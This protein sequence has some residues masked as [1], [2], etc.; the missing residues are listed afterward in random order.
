MPSCDFC[1]VDCKDQL[2]SCVCKKASYC[3]KD[4]QVKDWKTHK[5]S[6]PPFTVRQTPGGGRGLFASRRIK[7]GRI[8]LD[9]YPLFTLSLG[10]DIGMDLLS[11]LEFRT[12]YFP[13]IDEQTKATI[14][15]LDDP[16]DIFKTLD[17]ETV[18]EIIR[19]IPFV[20][21][22][23]EFITDEPN[24]ILRIFARNRILICGDPDL[25]GD[26]AEAGLY[27]NISLINHSCLPN[28]VDSWVMGDFRRHQV[29]ALMTIEKDEEILLSYFQNWPRV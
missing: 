6:C 24:K 8:I 18:E 26:N 16:A 13:N 2:K 21:L 7:E 25:Y 27:S 28:A 17:T 4:C 3:S 22:W 5:P 14:L 1:K 20:L 15:K 11:L 19:K 23:E 29:R 9:E 12:K 10:V